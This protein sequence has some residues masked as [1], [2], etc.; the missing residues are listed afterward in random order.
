MKTNE[1]I[2]N[3]DPLVMK[4]IDTSAGGQL[5]AEQLDSFIETVREQSEFLQDIDIITGIDASE[6]QMDTLGLASR[7]MRKGVEGT[8]PSVTGVTIDRRSLKPVELIMAFDITKR[9]LMRNVAKGTADQVINAAFAKQFKNDLIDLMINGD[10]S[11]LDDFLLITD[12]I[13]VKAK[14]DANVHKSNWADNDLIKDVFG[15]CVD[16]MPNKWM[17]ED[18]LKFYVSPKIQKQYQRELGEKNT[19]LGD[20]MTIDK[21][22]IYYEGIEVKT[23]PSLADTEVM[24]TDPKNLTIG[25]GQ[26]ML[27]ELFYNARKRVR[28]YTVTAYADANY[29][30]SDALVLYTQS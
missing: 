9:F 6:Y 13:L 1:E 7:I 25:I 23:I 2:L 28:E 5:N 14:A 8:A 15:A 16:A 21:P 3:D 4:A 24:L 27:V 10:D 17:N 30:I 11:S 29:K 12:G 26:E 19:Q 18:E 22:K 20:L